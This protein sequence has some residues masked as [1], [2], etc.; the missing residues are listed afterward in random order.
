MKKLLLTITVL[1]PLIALTQSMDK[2]Q[3]SGKVF[4]NE[5]K[6][7]EGVSVLVSQP[8]GKSHGILTNR[9]GIFEVAFQKPYP[10]KVFV[11]LSFSGY[12]DVFD[13]LDDKSFGKE[14]TYIM[15][16]LSKNLDAVNITSSILAAGNTPVANQ[17]IFKKEIKEKNL[18]QDLPVLLNTS[19]SLVYTTDAGAGVGY[20]S[21]R[22]R[23]S[24]QTRVNITVNG[25]PL[26]D[27]E[28]QG[29]FFV[30]MPDFASSATRID[31]QRGVGT[32]TN[33]AGAFGANMNIETI[34]RDNKQSFELNNSYG[35]FNTQKNTLG[36]NTGLI[37]SRWNLVGRM[38]R[39][40]S[41]GYID[42]A[43]SD[44][45]SYYFAASYRSFNK[46][47]ALDAIHFSG[48]ERTYQ[49]WWGT[50]E[51]RVAG[52]I[53]E[54]NA[55]ADRNF[56]TNEQRANLL[57]SG[58]TYNYYEYKN[59]TDN[60]TQNHFQLHANYQITRNLKLSLS[61]FY[62][63]GLGYFEQYM[64][65]QRFEDYGI[66]PYIL[67]QD[68]VFSTD[69]AR[70][71]WLDNHFYG[72]VYALF[73]QTN[74][75]VIQFGGGANQYVGDHY[76][77]I[78]WAK[79]GGNIPKDYRFANSLSTKNDFNN[80]I[81]CT[82]KITN[83]LSVYGDLQL[84][85]VN[86]DGHGLDDNRIP[87]SFD[88]DFMF[89]NPKGGV[90]YLMNKNTRIYISV[91]TAKREP[92]RMDFIESAPDVPKYE[93]LID[94]EFGYQF[95][96]PKYLLDIN[97]FYMDYRNQLVLT[98][99]MNSVGGLIRKNAGKSYREGIEIQG[100][101]RFGKK[102]KTG[103]NLTLSNS[104]IK[105]FKEVVFD[106]YGVVSEQSFEYKNTPISF[107]P[108]IVSAVFAELNINKSLT[109]NLTGKYVGAQYLDNSGRMES[110][111]D[112]YAVGDLRIEYKLPFKSIE[113]ELILLVNNFT[114][115]MY[116]S[117][118]YTYKYYLGNKNVLYTDK[119]LYP[120]A[121]INYLFG[122][123]I[124]FN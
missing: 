62:I 66:Q 12:E 94:Y 27:P 8:D 77:D 70:Q 26:N 48:K 95:R 41:D 106:W 53:E 36:F 44:L 91:A 39:I 19:P 11:R 3:L 6:P 102:L 23:G 86:Y 50:P 30:N 16:L 99:E 52:N 20:S 46:R 105:N 90:D 119:M 100:V 96:K 18:G 69:L 17:T 42:R 14:A 51:S 57:N 82:H 54:M 110:R 120:Q 111:L 81:K 59:E 60:Y 109:F 92:V 56:L 61:G 72:A 123:N 114:N 73:Y 97:L 1:S 74:K 121:G 34:N 31:I 101:Y 32:S 2:N 49:S 87:F 55:F 83:D 28:T 122:V 64:P 40:H 29:V 7:L 107:S 117:N 108:A 21:L 4:T 24:D 35:S 79:I 75:T 43:F 68:T 47:F 112:A 13:T 22:I 84:R 10:E 45:K 80:F 89:F 38:S 78:V 93:R 67:N 124:K 118:G 115:Q 9:E 85:M 63:R 25:I 104:R 71:L 15:Q 5:L 33:G 37:D 116:S 65:E 98:G 88:K 58:R 76:D 113:S 103:A